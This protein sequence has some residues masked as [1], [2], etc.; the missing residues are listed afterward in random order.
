MANKEPDTTPLLD[1]FLLAVFIFSLAQRS[2]II[3]KDKILRGLHFSVAYV[4][5]NMLYLEKDRG[6]VKPLFR[7]DSSTAKEKLAA[8][9]P[10]GKT[11]IME[12]KWGGTTKP[13][14]LQ[15]L[16]KNCNI[17]GKFGSSYFFHV[18]KDGSVK[19]SYSSAHSPDSIQ[20][21]FSKNL[22]FFQTRIKPRR[23]KLNLDKF[24]VLLDKEASPAIQE[25]VKN[26]I[27]Q[28]DEKISLLMI[29]R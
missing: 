23:K 17:Y 24:I 19:S 22:T 18:D 3:Q 25:E 16:C 5:N 15:K 27:S 7:V 12:I 28:N 2:E 14:E 10:N 8:L 13:E 9:S 21:Q 1:L 26:C 6:T 20:K 29:E 4:W 11:H